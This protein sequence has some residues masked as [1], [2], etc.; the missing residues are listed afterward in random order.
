M[1]EPGTGSDLQSV[2]TSA[3]MDGNH[4]ND[5]GSGVFTIVEKDQRYSSL[6]LY[7]MGLKESSDVPAWNWRLSQESGPPRPLSA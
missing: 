7:A 5:D 2:K 1:T 4:W 6:D 3:V